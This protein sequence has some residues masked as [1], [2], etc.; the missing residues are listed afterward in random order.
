MTTGPDTELILGGQRSGKSRC[1]ELRAAGWLAGAPGRRAVLL[2][3]AL[4]GDG[5]MRERIERHRLDRLERVPA[6]ATDEDCLD[7]A[8]G[9]FGRVRRYTWENLGL[10][11]PPVPDAT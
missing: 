7:L 8:A 9:F 5:E 1:G 10:D 6:M 3:T 11:A 2:A 4:G